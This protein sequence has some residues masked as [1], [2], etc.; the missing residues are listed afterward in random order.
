LANEADALGSA[1]AAPRTVFRLESWSA[2]SV[3]AIGYLGRVKT[4]VLPPEATPLR[5]TIII[6]DEETTKRT[7][8]RP[9]SCEIPTFADGSRTDP[10]K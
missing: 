3:S 6:D 4:T 1:F 5:A 2:R 9:Q 10:H 7:A 8:E